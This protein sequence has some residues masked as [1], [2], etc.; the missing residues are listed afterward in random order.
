MLHFAFH[1]KYLP[2]SVFIVSFLVF[3]VLNLVENLYHY[4]IGR[5]SNQREVAWV[6]PTQLDWIRIII[7]MV[8][9]GLLQAF[10][11][12]LFVGC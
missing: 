12:C 4:G 1:Y 3:L 7:V 8:L 11:T 10:F 2:K 9:F 6:M 5:H